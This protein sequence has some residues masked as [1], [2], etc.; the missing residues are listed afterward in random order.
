MGPRSGLRLT[1][2]RLLKKYFLVILS[3]AKNLGMDESGRFE[4]PRLRL[5]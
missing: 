1:S 4:I 3:E 5:G 2:E